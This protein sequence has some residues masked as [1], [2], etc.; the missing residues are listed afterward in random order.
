MKKKS[1]LDKALWSVNSYRTWFANRRNKR[2]PNIWAFGEW[3]GEK[4]GD[5]CTA[6]ANYVAEN[7]KEHKLYWIAKKGA[8]VS[9]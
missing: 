9:S 2:A 4:C 5:N 6:F 3:Y 1:A 7:H 8:D